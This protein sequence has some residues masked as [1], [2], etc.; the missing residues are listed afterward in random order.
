MTQGSGISCREKADPH[1]LAVIARLV[2]HC[3]RGLAIQYFVVREE[4]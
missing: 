1:P 4:L 2:R 3:A